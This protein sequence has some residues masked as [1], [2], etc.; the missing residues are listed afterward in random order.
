MSKPLPDP[1]GDD[2]NNTGYDWT[3]WK[4][5]QLIACCVVRGNFLR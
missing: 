5:F 1:A 2:V 3:G 4:L